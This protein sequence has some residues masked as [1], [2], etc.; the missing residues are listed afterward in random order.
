MHQ[1]SNGRIHRCHRCDPG[2]IPGWC[3]SGFVVY[4]F[5]NQERIRNSLGYPAG[6]RIP[7]MS[8]WLYR[9]L[10]CFDKQSKNTLSRISNTNIEKFA[11]QD[12]PEWMTMWPMGY[13]MDSKSIGL[14]ISNQRQPCG[15]LCQQHKHDSVKVMDSKSIVLSPQGFNSPR[16]RIACIIYIFQNS[17][18]DSQCFANCFPSKDNQWKH[19]PHLKLCLEAWGKIHPLSFCIFASSTTIH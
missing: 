1:W 9:L 16:C 15:K 12:T 8:H 6:V 2:S 10:F 17:R 11:M 19:C 3:I 18:N 13:V 14:C 5:G 4:G 7:T